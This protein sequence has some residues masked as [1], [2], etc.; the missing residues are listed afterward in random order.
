MQ[1]A[2]IGAGRWGQN[3]LRVLSS[4]PG[5]Q[6]RWCADS[7]PQRLRVLRE[8]YPQVGFTADWDTVLSDRQVQAVVIA[9]PPA[10]HFPLALACLQH[11]KHVLVEKPC[12]LDQAG[13]RTL[14]G[15]AEHERRVF[16]VGHVMEFNPALQWLKQYLRQGE[17]GRLLYLHCTRTNLGVVRQDVNVLWDLAV[18][19]LSILRFLLE[20]EPESV[21]AQGA[22]YL[23]AGV[24]DVV[25][26]TIWFPGNVLAQVHVSWLSPLKDRRVTLVGD[27][28]MAVFDDVAQQEKVKIYDRGMRALCE[29]GEEGSGSYRLVPRYGDIYL[30]AVEEREPLVG[31]CQH[32]LDCIREEKEPLTGWQDAL[33]VTRLAEAAE[34]SLRDHGSPVRLVPLPAGQACA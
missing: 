8:R 27:R 9:T 5:C 23:Q 14:G 30:P 34:Q 4:L 28:R 22:C 31:Q 26:L 15:L 10:T 12:C 7:N 19:D 6:V 18:H 16:M 11:G 17:L 2:V 24:Q 21:S 29:D 13:V 1:L 20:A 25:F 33:W 32:F 3:Y